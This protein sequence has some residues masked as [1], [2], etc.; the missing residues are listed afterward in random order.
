MDKLVTKLT[1]SNNKEKTSKI[2]NEK[3]AFTIDTTEI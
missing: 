2:R 3:D 1:R